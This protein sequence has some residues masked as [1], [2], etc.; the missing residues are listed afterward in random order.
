M[1]NDTRIALR[2]YAKSPGFAV[3]AVVALALGIG[4]NT[5]MFSAMDAVLLRQ[6]P[7]RDPGRLV[8]IWE[9][10]PL[11][12]GFLAQR[13]P[14]SMRDVIEWKRQSRLLEDMGFFQHSQVNLTGQDKPE[15]V[16]GVF[17]STNFLDM[18]GVK[19]MLG[20]GF[21]AADAPERKGQVALISYALFGRRFGKDRG[22]VGKTIRVDDAP[23]TI[24]GVLPAEFHLPAMWEGFDQKKPDVWVAMSAAGMTDAELDGRRNYVYGRLKSGVSLE[25][26]RAEMAAIDQRL[27][28]A[29]PKLNTTFGVSVYP[30]FVEDVGAVMLRTIVVLQSAVGFVLLI[31][32]ANVASLLLARAAGRRKEIAIRVALGAGRLR[33]VRQML[34]ESLLLSLAGAAGGIALAWGGIVAIRRLAPEDSYHLHELSLDWK[35]LAF[36][37]CAAILTG[38]IF[39]LAPSLQAA[40]QNVNEWLGKGGRWGGSGV[41]GRLRSVLVISEVALA[42]V[43]LAG[44]G[45][46]IRSMTSLLAMHPGFRTDHLLTAHVNLTAARYK[47]EKQVK[48][49]CDQLLDRVARVPGVKSVA[50]GEGFPMLDRL[51]ATRFRVEGETEPRRGAASL[52]DITRVGDGYFE[53]LRAPILRGRSFTRQDAE[54]AKPS[55]GVVNEALARRISQQGQAVGKVL[56][57]GSGDTRVTVIGIKADTHQMGL[58]TEVRPELF[59]PARSMDTIALVV[60]SAGDPLHLSSAIQSQVWA[61]DPNQPVADLKS[62]EQRMGEGLEQRRFN[63]LLFGIFAGLALLLASVGIYGVLAYAVSQRRQ[64][65]GIRIALGATPGNVAGLVLRQGLLLAAS[66]VAIGAAAAFGLTRWMASLIFGVSTTDPLTFSSVSALLIAIALLASYVPARRAVRVDPMQSLR[67][68]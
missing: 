29:Y 3:V 68:E 5:A 51:Q 15:Q 56:L 20:R 4:A 30:V 58:D 67:V 9:S 43:L 45:L 16:E 64:E 46:M 17:A 10:N 31:A 8:M 6:L 21:T 18:L 28:Q 59:L 44:A 54:Q 50:I 13:L 38:L 26:F 33:L 48:A 32:C 57:L 60:Q 66:G 34:V 37:L 41:S 47:D 7:Y 53:T 62:M 23:Y 42:L 25:Q 52:A 49:F 36:T 39:G 55:V 2:S 61:I 22:V 19:T 1:L 40:R 65:I 11:V 24:V 14:A 35:V 63:M 27:I 12:G